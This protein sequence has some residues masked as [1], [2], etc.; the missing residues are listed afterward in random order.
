MDNKNLESAIA[1]LKNWALE[2]HFNY[3]EVKLLCR[4]NEKSNLEDYQN[5]LLYLETDDYRYL[6]RIKKAYKK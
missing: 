3:E 4:L 2:H 6:D 1:R 5:A